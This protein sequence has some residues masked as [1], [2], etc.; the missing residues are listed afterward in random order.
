MRYSASL[1][2]LAALVAPSVASPNGFSSPK[3]APD[4][5]HKLDDC[6]C[7]PIYQKML[8]CQ[9]LKSFDD[10]IRDCICIPNPD[11]WYGWLDSC[12]DCL[13]PG[14][15]EDDDFFDNL[16]RTMTQL[17]V[18]CTEVGGGIK[19]DGESICASNA[20]FQACAALK[21]GGQ[22]SWAS[23]EMFASGEG[24][25]SGEGGNGT[26]VLDISESQ[27]ASSADS[28]STTDAA[29]PAATTAP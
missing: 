9:K 26:Y 11:G 15:L 23:Y 25:V 12:R 29:A 10:A 16:S 8:T 22:P 3:S 1:V 4:G 20:Y 17:L 27:G 5:P 2:L 21:T 6:G 18:S 14:S 7:T 28:T 13:S 24:F 19:S